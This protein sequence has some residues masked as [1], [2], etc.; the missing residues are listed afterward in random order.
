MVAEEGTSIKAVVLIVGGVKLLN[1]IDDKDVH[2]WN[3]ALFIVAILD[4]IVTL[5]NEVHAANVAIPVSLNP[6][7][8]VTD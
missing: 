4:G 1:V 6:V 5:V 2:P 7:E 8:N 3:V